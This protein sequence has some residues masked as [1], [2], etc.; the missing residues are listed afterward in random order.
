VYLSLSAAAIAVLSNFPL[1][2]YYVS[3]IGIIN[4][5]WLSNYKKIEFKGLLKKNIPVFI[6]TLFLFA[7]MFEPIRKLIKFKEFYDGGTTGLWKDTVDSLI[8]S[9]L[10][11]KPYKEILVIILKSFIGVS[12]VLMIFYFIYSLWFRKWRTFTEK[13]AV[14][15]LLLLFPC[16]VSIAQHFFTNSLFLIN[17][18]AL[19]FIPLFFIPFI[20]LLSD[21]TR[22]SKLKIVSYS[23]LCITSLALASHTISSLNGSY[24]LLWKYDSDTKKVLSDLETQIKKD[25]NDKIKLG[26][27][28]LF[29]PTVN[30]YR[31]TKNYIWLDKVTYDYYANKNYDYYY[32]ADSSMNFIKDRKLSVLMHYPIS[33]SYLVK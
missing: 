10:Y 12:A 27:M 13:Y 1:S 18:T 30:F 25:N 3:L 9:T 22:I 33:N 8:Q 31:T 7:V 14:S 11:G 28:W 32:L 15:F 21:I 2:L 4:I 5:Y 19:F 20:F 6:F 24:T 23:I 16:I 17:R 29:E 26:V